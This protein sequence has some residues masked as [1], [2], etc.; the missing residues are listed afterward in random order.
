MKRFKIH[1]LS[2]LMLTLTC[3]TAQAQT[4]PFDRF[5]EYKD[6]TYVY[7]SKAMLKLIGTNVIPSINGID[8]K[9]IGN[10]LNSIQII[11]SE[12]N[13]KESLK[14][15]AINIIKKDAY[16]NILQISEDNSKV[17]IYFKEGKKNSIIVMLNDEKS[18]TVLIVFSGTFTTSTIAGIF[19]N[20]Q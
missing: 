4:N 12:K 10:K 14:S 1:F 18:E 5:A 3:L 16:E 13:T 19:Q 20:I 9:E 6:V 17:D 11:T 15:E 8:V 7:I 2:M